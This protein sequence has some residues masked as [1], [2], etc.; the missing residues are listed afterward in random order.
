FVAGDGFRRLI[1]EALHLVDLIIRPQPDLLSETDAPIHYARQNDHAAIGIEPGI[2]DQRAQRNLGIALRRRHQV[3]DR[4][5]NL[6]YP[7]ALLGAGQYRFRRVQPD[8]RLDLFADALGLRGR[9]IDFVDDRNDLQV[10][11]QRKVGVGE[12]LR[13]HT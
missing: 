3:D 11:V 12:R 1:S 9:Q 10:V 4:F 7:R 13:L 5:Q 6:V 2:E 8:Y